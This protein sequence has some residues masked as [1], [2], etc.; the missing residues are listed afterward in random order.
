MLVDIEISPS[1]IA[2]AHK[3]EKL[4]ASMKQILRDNDMEY[5]KFTVTERDSFDGFIAEASFTEFLKNNTGLRED[6]IAR[7]GTDHPID[8]KTLEKIRIY[9]AEKEF[10]SSELSMIKDHFYDKW[11]LLIHGVRIDVKTAATHLQPS[12]HWRYGVSKIQMEKGNKDFVVLNYLIY[13]KDPKPEANADAIPIKCVL[14]G[15]L[16][17]YIVKNYPVVKENMAAGH[18]YF[19]ENYDTKVSEYR[20]ISEMF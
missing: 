1:L 13:N 17:V 11:D 20:D 9:P 5:D 2:E 19:I 7:W 16:P 6:E 10:S 14:I 4:R 8:G 3:F 12:G 15:C 18:K